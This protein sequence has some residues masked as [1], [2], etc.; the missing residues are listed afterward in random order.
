M[1]LW[2]IVFIF[3]SIPGSGIAGSCG[4][5]FIFTLL[6]NSILFHSGC[7]NLYSYQQCIRVPFSPH[8]H[9]HFSFVFFLLLL[10]TILTVLRWYPIVVLIFIYLIINNIQHLFMCLLVIFDVFFRKDFC[11][12][13]GHFFFFGSWVV[14]TNYIFWVLTSYWP[15]HLQNFLPFSRLFLFVKLFCCHCFFLQK[16]FM[17]I[18]SH[19]FLLLFTC[20]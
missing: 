2:I 11:S 18:M 4:N 8:L 17:L 14:W 7:T 13:S 1:Y 16:V 10:T 12:F 20:V 6:R 3:R 19:L 5:S 9:Q 15:C